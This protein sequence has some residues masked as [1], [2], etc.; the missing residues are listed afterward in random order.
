M[1]C[2]F[3]SFGFR[4]LGLSKAY[5]NGHTLSTPFLDNKQNPK[6]AYY[7]TDLS[8]VYYNAIIIYI[9]FILLYSLFTPLYM[10]KCAYIIYYT[11]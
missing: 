1:L 7:S 6:N 8:K 3:L 10:N 4:S 11:L 9:I 2:L 5:H